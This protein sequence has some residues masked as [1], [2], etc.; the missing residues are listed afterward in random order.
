MRNGTDFSYAGLKTAV[1]QLV[2]KHLPSEKDAAEAG[3]EAVQAR[4]KIRQDMAACFQARAVQHLAQRV[5]RA[6]SWA[7]AISAAGGTRLQGV[8][9]AGGVACNL[10]V[11]TALAEAA[12]KHSLK[13]FVPPPRLC[14]D[15]GV[16]VAWTGIERLKLG[17]WEAPPVDIAKVSLFVE[18]RPRWPLGP[19]DARCTPKPGKSTR[20]AERS[21]LAAAAPTAKRPRP[22]AEANVGD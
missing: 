20:K 18:T 21:S 4:H 17:L 13:M 6:L 10:A 16:M 19:R 9:V 7:H 14:V 22:A 3:A 2:Q 5:E 12:A 8:V 1:R 11:R 15:N